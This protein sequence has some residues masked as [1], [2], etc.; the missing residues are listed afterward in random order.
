MSI[1]FRPHMSTKSMRR[2]R[3]Q[4]RISHAD[5]GMDILRRSSRQRTT[6]MTGL[7]NGSSRSHSVFTIIIEWEACAGR[8]ARK[9]CIYFIDLAGDTSCS[10]PCAQ[11]A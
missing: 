4:V 10:L 2:H 1:S 8:E 7:N 9:S 5:Q 11:L 3:L 6:A